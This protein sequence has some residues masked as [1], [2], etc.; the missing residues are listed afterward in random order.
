MCR[1]ISIFSPGN[2]T[3]ATNLK[4]TA[5]HSL[6]YV[7]TET[8]QGGVYITENHYS[9]TNI[10]GFETVLV[11]LAIQCGPSAERS[12]GNILERETNIEIAGVIDGASIENCS[13]DS[14]DGLIRILAKYGVNTDAPTQLNFARN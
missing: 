10:S 4:I 14:L 1:L 6:R 3:K 8:D 11:Q 7:Y 12:V 13:T 9:V 5:C 2:E